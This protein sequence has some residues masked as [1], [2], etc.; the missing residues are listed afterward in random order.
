[1]QVDVIRWFLCLKSWIGTEWQQ[2]QKITQ[3]SVEPLQ[4]LFIYSRQTS[5]LYSRQNLT[6]PLFTPC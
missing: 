1:M 4:T 2:R 5:T 3:R 6:Q